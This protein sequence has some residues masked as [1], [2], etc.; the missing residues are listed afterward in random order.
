M[1]TFHDRILQ[2]ML[3]VADFC[4]RSTIGILPKCQF[5]RKFVHVS[6]WDFFQNVSLGGNLFT[7]HDR[8]LAEM[9]VLEEICSRST[10]GFS[11][12]CQFGGI[13]FTFHDRNSSKMSVLEE[14]WSRF[15]IGSLP[16]CLFWRNFVHVSQ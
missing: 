8:N 12:K 7:F 10:I 1:F 15:T 14:F 6:R 4:S 16:K 9:S 3:V 5:W 11:P 2:K 13:L